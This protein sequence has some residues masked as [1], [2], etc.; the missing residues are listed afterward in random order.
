MKKCHKCKEEKPFSAFS[1][2]SV[3]SDKLQSRCRAC[4]KKYQEARRVKFKEEQREYGR[5]YVAQKR[6]D[7]D[8][9]LVQL[10]HQ[11][12]ARSRSKGLEFDLTNE[13]LKDKYPADGKCP[14]YGFYLEW[15]NSGFRE[16]S[17]SIDRID[18]TKGYT[19]DNI[20]I[21]SWKANRL[22]ADFTLEDIETL[23]SFL[24]R[25]R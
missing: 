18:S 20:Q 5:N 22:K 25:G 23:V 21:I 7:P 14:V 24:K 17:P 15:G 11:A 3:A 8:W 13:A 12:K 6:K 19:K 9:R 4:D 16:K 10:L 2:N 1:K